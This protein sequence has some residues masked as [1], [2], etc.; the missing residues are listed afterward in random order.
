M[1]NGINSLFMGPRSVSSVYIKDRGNL[2]VLIPPLAYSLHNSFQEQTNTAKKPDQSGFRFEKSSVPSSNYIE[3]DPINITNNDDFISYANLY[4]WTGNGSELNPFI[5]NGLEISNTENLIEIMNTSLFFH[6]TNCL[7]TGEG[8][9]NGLYFINVSNS[10]II[11][12]TIEDVDTGI[13]IEG[14]Q[15]ITILHNTV[16]NTYSS[17]M[18]LLS[19]VNVS[20]VNNYVFDE[21]SRQHA[22]NVGLRLKNTDNSNITSNTVFNQSLGISLENSGSNIIS[23]NRAEYNRFSGIG[24]IIGDGAGISTRNTI[25]NNSLSNNGYGIL[26]DPLSGSNVICYNYVYDNDKGIHFYSSDTNQIHNNVVY[27]NR[28]SG[29]YFELA[30]FNNVSTN[31]F[32][33]NNPSG[34]SQAFDDGENNFFKNNFWNELTE[35]DNEE[36]G[37]VDVPYHISGIANNQDTTPRVTAIYHIITAPTL[38]YPIGGEILSGSIT[39]QWIASIDPFHVVSYTLY[40]SNDGINWNLLVE[41]LTFNNYNWDTSTYLNTTSYMIKVVATCSEGLTSYCISDYRFTIQHQSTNTISNQNAFL[42]LLNS[43]IGLSFIMITSVIIFMGLL[44][45][46]NSRKTL[47]KGRMTGEEVLKYA[48]EAIKIVTNTTDD[49]RKKEMYNELEGI[50]GDN[51]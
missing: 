9:G 35:P 16:V 11:N 6:I 4:N 33:G 3:C 10:Y 29:I 7:L 26:L 28:L 49:T 37:I 17:G 34:D 32:I 15:N 42:S 46:R 51:K 44:V 38:V 14:S 47:S 31:D 23:S 20:I 48:E 45:W 25:C 12:N 18:R 8:E 19:D 36:D 5:I 21:V 13:F 22:Y 27:N 39:V 2:E 40:Y 30:N 41:G 43:V 50:K 1:G 24:L